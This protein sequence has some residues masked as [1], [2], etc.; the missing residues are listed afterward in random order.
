MTVIDVNDQND[1]EKFNNMIGNGYTIVFYYMENCG[2]CNAMKDEWS[3][4]ERKIERDNKYDVNV[5]RVNMR[6][7]NDVDGPSD[8]YGFPTIY[9]LKDGHKV[10][11]HTGPRT[12]SAFESTLDETD[13]DVKRGYKNRNNKK[14]GKRKRKSKN[15]KGGKRKMKTRKRRKRKNKTHNT[16]KRQ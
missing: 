9:V 1:A 16:R 5:A 3:S 15:K 6:A 2:H 13:V 8:L 4:L 14:S 12:V 11:E 10:K 7:L